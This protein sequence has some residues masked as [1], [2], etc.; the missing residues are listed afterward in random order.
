MDTRTLRSNTLLMLT[1]TI[2]G[3]AFV[4]QRIGMEH[5]GPFTFNGIRF[6]VGSLSLIPVMIVTG[7]PHRDIRHPSP[8]SGTRILMTGGVLAGAALFSGASLQQVGLMYTTAG[9]AG[10]IT[11]LYVVLVPI[12]G[13]VW[14]QHADAGTWLGAMLAATGLYFLSVTEQF[15][16][17][18][19]DFLELLGALV[20]ACHVLLIGWFSPK[21]S[22]IRLSFIQ[23]SVCSALSLIT[24]AFTETVTLEGLWGATP[25]ILYGGLGSVG[26]AYTLQVVAQ[27][28]ARASHAAIILCLESPFAALG[29]WLILDEMMTGRGLFGC[30]L[31]L[32]GML[33]SQLYPQFFSP[34]AEKAP[35]S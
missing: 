29:G 2:W 4:A 32:F 18:F 13:L 19:G 23:F 22:A 34:R 26:I 28:H 24:A 12:V 14:K 27:K 10:F 9:K 30:G 11:G 3:F 31:M 21:I 33:V 1:A 8:R 20:W 35:R 6:A 16:I 7:R 17:S 15:T 5:V 25:A